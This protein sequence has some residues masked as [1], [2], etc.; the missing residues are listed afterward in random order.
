MVTFRC[1]ACLYTIRLHFR[2]WDELSC[3]PAKWLALCEQQ[4]VLR[5][6][7]MLQRARLLSFLLAENVHDTIMWLSNICTR[8]GWQQWRQRWLR[9]KSFD[10]LTFHGR[11][12]E[13]G[14]HT[15]WCRR[16]VFE[17]NHF[18]PTMAVLALLTNVI[19]GLQSGGSACYSPMVLKMYQCNLR[20]FIGF[21]KL[22]RSSWLTVYSYVIVGY[23]MLPSLD[24]VVNIAQIIVQRIMICRPLWH[25]HISLL[26]LVACL[27]SFLFFFTFLTHHWQGFAR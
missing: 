15:K 2:R 16:L 7:G 20:A 13:I 21:K 6:A 26:A 22:D 8:G 9:P 17:C 1:E 23:N 18:S 12:V 19:F 14:G 10:E 4:R 5:D 25:R 11:C 27:S 24:E 3:Y